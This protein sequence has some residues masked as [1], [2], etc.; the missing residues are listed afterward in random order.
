[1]SQCFTKMCTDPRNV[2]SDYS[3][4][5]QGICNDGVYWYISHGAGTKKYARNYGA[6]HRVDWNRIGKKSSAKKEVKVNDCIVYNRGRQENRRCY[7]YYTSDGEP[8]GLKVGEM[9][10]GDI[11]CYKGYIFIPTYQHEPD[12]TADAQ[13]MIFSAKTF[14]FICSEVLEKPGVWPFY[15]HAWCAVNPVDECLYTSDSHLGN[16][17]GEGVSPVM[18]YKINFSNLNNRRGRVF[19][20]LTPKGIMLYKNSKGESIKF[21]AGTQGGCF[22]PYGT[23][24]LS[25]GFGSRKTNDGVMAFKLNR[26]GAGLFMDER[27]RAYYI[28][29]AKGCPMQTQEEKDKDWYEACWQ[30]RSVARDN[31]SLTQYDAYPTEAIAYLKDD[32]TSMIDFSFDGDASVYPEEPEGMTYWDL[33]NRISGSSNKRNMRHGQLHVLRLKNNGGGLVG[34]GDSFGEQVGNFFEN[35]VDAT[36]DFFTEGKTTGTQDTFY[37]ENYLVDE[38]ESLRYSKSYDPTKLKVLYNPLLHKWTIVDA[39]AN[40][41]LKNFRTETDARNAMLEMSLYEKIWYFHLNPFPERNEY[42]KGIP[43]CILTNRTKKVSSEVL[44]GLVNYRV[45]GFTYDKGSFELQRGLSGYSFFFR[46]K[47]KRCGQVLHLQNKGD[48]DALAALARNF[49]KMRT[50]HASTNDPSEQIVWFE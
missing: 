24:Y 35:L 9:H 38:R 45:T 36:V 39:S 4:D 30:I 47:K 50:M 28:W 3:N 25:T 48:C 41:A 34:N 6:I 42:P 26:Y 2:E 49:T 23:M 12:G 31:N 15:G 8:V 29:M 7:K 5:V 40:D 16:N 27:V 14:D 44:K 32:G 20:L 22:D 43:Y 21:G 13:I 46:Y 11:D 1:M 19:S 37:L 17:F 10:F 33:R 18:A